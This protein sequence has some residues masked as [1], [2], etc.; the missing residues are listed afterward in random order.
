[1]KPLQLSLLH[2]QCWPLASYMIRF[3][4]KL[5]T[6]WNALK[7]P[8]GPTLGKHC[9]KKNPCRNAWN[10]PNQQCFL[11]T[12]WALYSVVPFFNNSERLFLLASTLRKRRSHWATNESVRKEFKVRICTGDQTP[13]KELVEV[14]NGRLENSLTRKE[15]I[16]VAFSSSDQCIL[17]WFFISSST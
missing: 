15:E 10:V 7:D 9:Y 5:Q 11:E 3:P 16:S 4:N 14:D 1:M 6:F 13:A 17:V 2:F 12:H 8:S